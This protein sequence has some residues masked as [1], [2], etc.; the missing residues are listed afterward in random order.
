V[1]TR[2]IVNP[3]SGGGKTA[4]R[5]PEVE[6]QLREALPE[7]DSVHTDGPGS[8]TTLA[9]RALAEGV[10]QIVAVGGD[11][12]VSE[13]VNGFF[14]GERSLAPDA[15]LA[16]VM[17]GTGGDFRRSL[18]F[19]GT[20]DAY[21]RG[22][23]EGPVRPI[24]VGRLT[25]VDHQGRTATRYF[26]NIASFGMSGAVVNAV[27]RATFSKRFGGKFAFKWASV[28]TGMRHENQRVR[29]R[30][31]DHFDQEVV[32]STIAVCNGRYFGG[33]MHVAPKARLDDHVFDATI[34][35]DFSVW[36]F[37][38]H[39]AKLYDG[40]HVEL[41]K[42]QQVSGRKFVATPV[43][44]GNIDL[45]VDGEAPGRLPAT[46]EVVPGALRVRFAAEGAG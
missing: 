38:K 27:N 24:D 29:L 16:L 9:R 46:F 39:N 22:L 11:G 13:V 5:W 1:K 42:V 33:G 20:I 44:E 28:V 32:F 10:E 26:D 43:G 12:T 31:D 25:F 4:Q 35:G 14:E 30:V 40:T 34:W 36:E 17:L 45:D 3:R 21:V 8:A 2:A 19:P 7:F 15:V 6:R 23:L 41:P 18:G 37:L